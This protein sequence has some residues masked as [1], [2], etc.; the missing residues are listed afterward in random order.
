MNARRRISVALIS[1]VCAFSIGA[2]GVTQAQAATDHRATAV[3]AE[4][5]EQVTQE[6]IDELTR[7]LEA[8]DRGEHLGAD[9]TF[10]YEATKAKFGVEL[11]DALQSEYS[12]DSTG[13]RV[14]RSYTSCL[15]NA[16]GVG[17]ITGVAEKVQEHIK[18]K[19]WRK[20]AE[21]GLKEAAKRGI[22]IAGKGGVAGLAASLGVAA[23]TC[24]WL[25]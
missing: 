9:G 5:A 11:A 18:K 3:E 16:I 10:N 1:A 14:E 13:K 25:G 21:I 12:K 24:S 4:Q 17:G 15:L 22:K 23:V 19:N 6:Q 20:V 7:Y 8:I 2:T